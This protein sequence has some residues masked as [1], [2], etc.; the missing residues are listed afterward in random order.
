MLL[1]LLLICSLFP[2]HPFSFYSRS[3]NPKLPAR[4]KEAASKFNA[5]I[6]LP[7]KNQA[8][9]VFELAFL[10]KFNPINP[11]A[12][13]IN[14]PINT[15]NKL[16]SATGRKHGTNGWVYAQINVPIIAADFHTKFIAFGQ[17][18]STF[19]NIPFDSTLPF[20]FPSLVPARKRGRPAKRKAV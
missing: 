18:A 11:K 4:V 13:T 16:F 2:T 9:I 20:I 17:A 12:F 19:L 6:A 15:N 14:V 1:I 8:P 7:R 10:S 3:Q 5:Q